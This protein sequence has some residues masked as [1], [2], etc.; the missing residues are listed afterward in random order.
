MKSINIILALKL[1]P[2]NNSTNLQPIPFNA[3]PNISRNINYHANS[4]GNNA[5]S[6]SSSNSPSPSD[7]S[8]SVTGLS[9]STGI[10]PQSPS[11]P[12]AKSGNLFWSILIILLLII[13][14]IIFFFQHKNKNTKA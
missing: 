8:A 9:D 13:L 3:T 6:G 11:Q 7:N 14:G 12:P 10:S 5:I 2:A 4:T 1:A